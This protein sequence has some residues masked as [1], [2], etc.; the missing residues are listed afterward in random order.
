[1]ELWSFCV[2]KTT[3]ELLSTHGTDLARPARWAS[4]PGVNIPNISNQ[5]RLPDIARPSSLYEGVCE[6]LALAKYIRLDTTI[7]L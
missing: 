2:L 5:L 3:C 4:A 7:G 6:A 1:M